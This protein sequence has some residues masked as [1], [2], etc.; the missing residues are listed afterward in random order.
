MRGDLDNIVKPILDA[1][2]QHVFV[3]DRQVDRIL[4]QRLEPD[5]ML[6]PSEGASTVL[7]QAWNSER[8]LLYARVSDTF[9]KEVV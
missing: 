6:R 3:D 1:L 7:K 2:K 9:D 5:V 4:V 8:P